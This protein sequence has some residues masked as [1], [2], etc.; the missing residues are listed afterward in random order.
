MAVWIIWGVA[1][2]AYGGFRLWYDNW[3]GPL[4]PSE[5]D[6]FLAH[7]AHRE[8]VPDD[9]SASINPPSTPD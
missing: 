4:K 7:P 3:S 2:L 6:A 5:I 9:A 8:A 1:L